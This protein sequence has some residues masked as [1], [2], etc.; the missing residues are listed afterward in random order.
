MRCKTTTFPEYR[1]YF[2]DQSDLALVI[3][4]SV[5]YVNNRM[6]GRGN[7]SQNDIRIITKEIERRKAI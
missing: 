1:K 3:N 7:W 5:S 2:T 6:N 4:K